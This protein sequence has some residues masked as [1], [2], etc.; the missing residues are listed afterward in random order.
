MVFSIIPLINTL[1][2]LEGLDTFFWYL[3]TDNNVWILMNTT[4]ISEGRHS[5]TILFLDVEL[6]RGITSCCMDTKEKSQ[7]A[8]ANL[9]I[10]V[11]LMVIKSCS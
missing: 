9:T 5:V 7:E 1:I 2:W 6:S 8:S 3:H 11:A 4:F 10:P